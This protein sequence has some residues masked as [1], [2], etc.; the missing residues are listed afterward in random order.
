M[1]QTSFV[2]DTIVNTR[3]CEIEV[4]KVVDVVVC[5]TRDLRLSFTQ[6]QCSYF[7]NLYNRLYLYL[8]ILLF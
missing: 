7:S 2:V 1:S 3:R 8:H 4:R 5:V 6:R